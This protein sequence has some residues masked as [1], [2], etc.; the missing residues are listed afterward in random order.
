MRLAP[1][2]TFPTGI[3][4]SG[5]ATVNHDFWIAETPVHYELWYLVRIWAEENGYS[6]AN[7]GMEGSTTK[8]G[9]HPYYNNIGKPP[10]EAKRE[11]VTMVSWYDS[12]VWCNALSEMLGYDPVYMFEDSQGYREIVRNATKIDHLHVEER[13]KNGFRLPTSNEWELAARYKGSNRSHR[14]IEYP[15]GSGNYWTPGNYASG[16]TAN[17]NNTAASQKVSWY[18]VNS[19]QDVGQKPPSG[20]LLGLYDMSGNVWEW[21]STRDGPTRI[22]RGGSWNNSVN[23]MQVG[24]VH[25]SYPYSLG[26]N[27]GFRLL[28]TYF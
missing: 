18:R 8:G 13:E 3:D 19:T 28:R 9:E 4:D 2:A 7:T 22:R 27:Y 12:I 11:P 5:E 17:V 23:L 10:T 20:N 15:G 6:F 21:C 24:R 25:S 14:A 26:H 1:A 16:A